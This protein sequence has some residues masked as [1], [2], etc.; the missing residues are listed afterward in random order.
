MKL[1]D[2]MTSPVVRIH[3]EETVAVAARTLTHYNI[4]ILP[5][6]GNDG[7][8]CGLVTDRDIVTRCL[9]AGKQPGETKVEDIMTHGVVSVRPDMEASQVAALMARRQI[10]RL[11][12]VEDGQLCGMVTLGDLSQNEHTAPDAVDALAEITGNVGHMEK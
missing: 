10:R 2:V 5:V 12:V 7:R 3:P 9:A 6:C 11:P 8:L 1:R 4:G